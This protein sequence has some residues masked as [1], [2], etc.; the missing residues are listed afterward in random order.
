MR[1]L[2]REQAAAVRLLLL[3]CF[4]P[5]E[6]FPQ[7]TISGSRLLHD[8]STFVAR[9]VVYGNAP[10]GAPG[11]STLGA[12]DCL[13]PRDF[14]LI[15]ALGA[16]TILTR[17][18]VSP[19][20]H[21]F[22]RTLQS[23]NLYWIAGFSLDAYGAL[24]DAGVRARV[25]DDFAAYAAS[26]AAEPRLLAISFGDGAQ[27]GSPE[28]YTLLRQASARLHAEHPGLLVTAAVR[29]PR[30]I[31]AFDRATEDGSLPDLAFWSLDL[32]GHAALSLPLD[33]VTARTS[34]PVLISGFGVDAFD[35]FAAAADFEAQS[36][37]AELLAEELESILRVGFHQVLGGLYSELT[38]QWH[39]GGLDPSFHGPAGRP[40][41]SSPDGVVNEAWTGLF[42]LTRSGAPGLDSLRARPAY[43]RLAQIWHGLVPAELSFAGPP[44]IAAGGFRNAASGAAM[45]A[46]G[47]LFEASGN[48]LSAAAR[49]TSTPSD[50]PFHLGTTSVCFDGVAS[51]LFLAEPGLVR[52][53]APWSAKLGSARAMVYR[54]GAASAPAAVEIREAA[55]GI[56]PNGVFRP[57]L[58]C[59]VNEANGV[60][61][62][63]Y[64]EVYGS[65]LGAPAAPQ[66]NGIAPEA[67]LESAVLPSARLGPFPIPVLYS[68]LFPGAP[69]VYQ[70]NVRISPD[71]GPGP[72]ELRL[73]R[74]GAFSNGYL[75][76]IIGEEDP[77]GFGFAAPATPEILVQE[78]GPGRTVYLELQGFNGFC[79]LVRF[80][81][82]GIPPGIRASIPVGLPGQRIPL[83][84]WAESGAAR[85]ESAPI[86][87]TALS[88][89]A[90]RPQ[91]RVNVT[92]LPGRGDIRLRIVS[93]GWLSGAPEASFTV[94]DRVIYRVAGGGPGRGFNFLTMDPAGGVIGEVRHFDTWESEEAVLAMEDYLNALPEG[95]VVLGAIADDGVL[96]ITGQTRELIRDRLGSGLIDLVE[97]QWSWAILS[98]VGAARPMAEGMMPNGTV[99]LDRTLSFPLDGLG[100]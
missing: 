65:G 80:E 77:P 3:V 39:R 24:D 4:A 33:E 14:P 89:L 12:S 37:Y 86:T 18:R 64:L 26:W 72:V 94:E 15:A 42:G 98:R 87:V 79:G 16:N 28:L 5:L 20:D 93:G 75:L 50:L 99:V 83:T 36:I 85:V 51:P 49:Q 6:A 71:A 88:T 95:A 74:N 44:L 13:Y 52:G 58:P 82:S 8:G 90:E 23:A 45:L 81:L 17:E 32:T 2:R 48:E 1:R 35:D 92:V 41:G 70:T 21:V 84:V 60:P 34:K 30:E 53:L 63:S 66:Q 38:D 19:A 55:P 31:G 54:A 62:G 27:G 47:G 78:G 10:I 7:F 59:P 9:G 29:D 40:S 76:R 61:P 68:G 43:E 57:G 11:F 67:P 25:L 69:G 46:P 22:R 97:Y 96:K 56:L 91:Q 100:P 73:E